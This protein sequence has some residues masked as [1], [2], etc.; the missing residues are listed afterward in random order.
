MMEQRNLSGLKP[1]GRAVLIK[2]YTPERKGSLIE[3]PPAVLAQTQMV[4]CREIVIELGPNAWMD[5]PQARALPGDKVL[6]QKYTGYMA[7]EDVTADGETYRLVN[8]RDIFC[9]IEES[10]ALEQAA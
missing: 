1:L 6:V 3:L 5:E 2:P 9:K 4:D 8:D 7:R 10:E